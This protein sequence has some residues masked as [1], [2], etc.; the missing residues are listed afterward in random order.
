MASVRQ[1]YFSL[2]HWLLLA[3]S[4]SVFSGLLHIAIIIGG[5][6]WYRF[7]GAG[8]NMA[9]LEEQGSWIPGTITAGIALILFLWG[10]YAYSGAGLTR[11]LPWLK[12]GLMIIAA[13][14]LLRGLAVIPAMMIAP[15]TV[16][17]FLLS[18]S[19]IST[20]F[21]ISYVIGIRQMIW[22]KS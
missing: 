15:V 6:D 11:P 7:F 3:G 19:V 17:T 10:L 16:D 5:A 21:G 2:N 22:E 1:Q 13:I 18:S 4:L 8:E 9:N 14:Y 12:T 20:L